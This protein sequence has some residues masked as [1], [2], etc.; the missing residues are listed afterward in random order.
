M[1]NK[2]GRTLVERALTAALWLTLGLW[3]MSAWGGCVVRWGRLEAMVYAGSF[4]GTI[5]PTER[6]HADVLVIQPYDRW[7]WCRWYYEG[8]PVTSSG[9][10]DVTVPGW[11]PVALLSVLVTLVRCFRGGEPPR[12]SC[13]RCGY[14]LRGNCSGTCPECGAP[15]PAS[16]VGRL[17]DEP[18]T[19]VSL[20]RCATWVARAS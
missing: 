15:V 10:V 17:A 9:I 3:I 12:G 2:R 16:G 11:L 13:P 20:V 18:Q 4:E 7:Q 6:S 1:S 8:P 5:W 19:G 14:D